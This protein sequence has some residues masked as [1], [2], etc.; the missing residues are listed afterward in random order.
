MAHLRYLWFTPPLKTPSS[1][2]SQNSLILYIWIEAVRGTEWYIREEEEGLSSGGR[3]S[4]L[5]MMSRKRQFPHHDEEE[6]EE[7]VLRGGGIY[8]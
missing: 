2:S 6:G 1:S 7:G 4:C 3:G 5:I 8:K